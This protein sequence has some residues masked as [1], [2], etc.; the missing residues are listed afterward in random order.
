MGFRGVPE[1]VNVGH[2]ALRLRSLT[3]VACK[4]CR[5]WS[6][7]AARPGRRVVFVSHIPKSSA[8]SLGAVASS[9]QASGLGSQERKTDPIR[10]LFVEDD[11]YYREI[12]GNELSDHGFAV[13]SFADGDSLLSSLDTGVDADVIVLDWMLPDISGI[14]LLPQLRRHG[15]KLPVVFLT[16][17]SQ[18]AHESLAFVRGAIDF[19]DKTRG[20]EILIRRLRLAAEAGNVA[21]S[22]AGDKRF[23]CGKLVLRTNVSRAYWNGTDVGLTLSEYDIVRLLA[24]NVARYLTYREIYNLQYYEGF[25]AGNGKQGYRANVRSTIKRIRKKFCALDPTFSE[26]ETSDSL[27]YRW[28]GLTV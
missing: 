19:I 23:V 1:S 4:I 27:G 12:V 13:S 6:G 25:I 11:E 2:M 18:I 10:V 26:I 17:H 24:S 14:D 28:R 16:S 21:A 7:R 15:V 8:R 5:H 3:T 22:F 9:F 20:V